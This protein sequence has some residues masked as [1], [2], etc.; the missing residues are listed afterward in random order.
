[1]LL[2]QRVLLALALLGLVPGAA[3]QAD[4][5][6]A[7]AQA[8]GALCLADGP[9]GLPAD[10]QHE[11]CLACR[12]APMPFALA[13]VPHLPLPGIA[14]GTA[15]PAPARPAHAAAWPAYAPRA[16]PGMAG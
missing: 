2:L 7:L 4:P 8:A 16:P 9:D 5:A 12:V 10:P 15:T 6:L 3:P 1:L 14:A 11:H 13:D